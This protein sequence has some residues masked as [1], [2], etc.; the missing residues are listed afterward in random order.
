MF[1][2]QGVASTIGFWAMED[3]DYKFVADAYLSALKALAGENLDCYLSI[4]APALDEFQ[5]PMM[6]IAKAG[7]ETGIGIHF[8]ALAPEEA[9]RAFALI[10][11]SLRHC[12]RIGC[13]LP[14]RWRRSLRDA[15]RAIELGLYVRV[16]KGQW[17]DPDHP[18]MDLREGYLAVIDR[19]AGRA[20]HVAV[21]TH[22]PPLAREALRRLR[23][24]GTPCGLELLYGLPMKAAIRPAN[25]IGAPVR[26][27]VP[28][29]KAWLP[30]RLK[31][32]RKNPRI[33]WWVMRDAILSR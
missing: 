20:R 27:Y 6:E 14:G 5:G 22:D 19:L 33:L 11:E 16:V 24:A 7:R 18:D 8:D 9:D 25:E 28:Y 12:P 4:K 29:G 13:T 32:I 15:E 3:A 23:A 21:A 2:Q 17:E 1:A 30:Y 10:A 26:V 31:Q